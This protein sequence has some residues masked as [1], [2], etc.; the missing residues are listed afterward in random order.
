MFLHGRAVDHGAVGAAEVLQKGIVEDGGDSGVA[1]AD[2]EIVDM[3]IVLRFAADGDFILVQ[4]VFLDH[5]AVHAENDFCHSS[6]F[7]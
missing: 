2:R 3:D 1:T 7:F 4:G 6:A 5:H